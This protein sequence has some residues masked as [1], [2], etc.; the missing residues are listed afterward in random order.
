MFQTPDSGFY[1]TDKKS[2]YVLHAAI[3][4]NG[5]ESGTGSTILFI[6]L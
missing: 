6:D 5:A 3:S 4:N 2:P 1:E